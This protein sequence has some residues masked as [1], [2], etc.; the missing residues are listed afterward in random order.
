MRPQDVVGVEL[1]AAL[2]RVHARAQVGE[3]PRCPVHHRQRQARTQDLVLDGVVVDQ[4]SAWCC[5]ARLRQ[6][7]GQRCREHAALQRPRAAAPSSCAARRAWAFWNSSSSSRRSIATRGSADGAGEQPRTQ[8]DRLHH[9]R[10]ALEQSL[11]I[12]PPRLL[13]QCRWV[14]GRGH[15]GVA[16]RPERS[17]LS[18]LHH[19][20]GVRDR[21]GRSPSAPP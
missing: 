8:L 18:T 10:Q 17:A 11:C 21:R 13:G 7:A 16:R 4:A 20:P 5:V 14:G 15:G 3:L 1:L 2:E 12:R 6:F 19:G 9:C